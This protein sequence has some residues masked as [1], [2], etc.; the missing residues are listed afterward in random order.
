[1]IADVTTIQRG[2]NCVPDG[3]A[4]PQTIN[5][6]KALQA[7]IGAQWVDGDYGPDTEH[8]VGI[9]EQG[10][11]TQDDGLYGPT[12]NSLVRVVQAGCRVGIDGVYGSNTNG[13]VHRAQDALRNAGSDPGGSD[14]IYGPGTRNAVIDFQHKHGL[15]ADGLLGNQTGNALFGSP[16][17][18]PPPPGPAPIG[19]TVAGDFCD[20][21]EYQGSVDWG[22]YKGSGRNYAVVK[23]S[24]G[25]DYR[26]PW[27]SSARVSDMRAH[28]VRPGYYHFLRPRTGRGGDV[29]ANFF[30]DVVRGAGGFQGGDL[31]PVLDFE[32]TTLNPTDTLNYARQFVDR[33]RGAGLP[34][35]ILYT[36]PSFWVESTPGPRG[37]VDNL[38]GCPLWIASYGVSSPQIP[39]AWV[40]ACAWQFADNGRVSG[41]GGSVDVNHGYAVPVI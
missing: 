24:E 35:V 11:G 13:G 5:A 2:L 31:W 37:A 27:F 9:I 41:I 28:G 10:L 4:G 6:I 17:P 39:V 8:H 23:A 22:A 21:S 14:G 20:I 30:L 25:Q 33:I 3:I 7:G 26:D 15:S 1:M 12:C 38:G 19:G 36:Y 32:V 34:G 40:S 18:P 29:E 16:P